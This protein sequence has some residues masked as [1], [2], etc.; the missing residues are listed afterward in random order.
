MLEIKF[1]R[2]NLSV[3]REALRKRNTDADLEALV[4][5]EDLHKES[6]LEIENLRFRPQ[7]CF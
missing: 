3:V 7:Q 1:V 5:F 2:Q 6:L 4:G